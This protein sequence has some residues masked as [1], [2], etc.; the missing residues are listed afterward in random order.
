MF[1]LI[2]GFSDLLFIN[3]DEELSTSLSIS[4]STYEITSDIVCNEPRPQKKQCRRCNRRYDDCYFHSVN[5]RKCFRCI[6]YPK[7]LMKKEQD[8]VKYYKMC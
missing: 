4:P 1:S 8:R 5:S 2:T 7:R 3:R 6:E